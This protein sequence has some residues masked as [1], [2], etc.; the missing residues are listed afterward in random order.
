[1][2]ITQVR[3]QH[4]RAHKDYVLELSPETTV[5]TGANGSGK[6]SLTEAVYIALRGSSFK[7][8]D[9]DV[10]Q[11]DADW[12][13]ID[14]Q[15]QDGTTRTVKYTPTAETSKKQFDIDGKKHARL[16]AGKKHPVVLFEPEHLQLFSGSP[17]RRRRFIDQLIANVEPAYSTI[18]SRYDRALKQRNAAL[19]R[20]VS[21]DNLFAWNVALS[22][23]GEKIISKRAEYIAIMNERIAQSYGTIASTGD[24]ITVH[25][26]AYNTK[27]IQQQLLLQLE[28]NL[29]KDSIVG[30]TT[31][32][33]HRHDIT[34][35]F[36]GNDVR[37]I[38]S[39]GEV[40]SVVVALKY[41]EMKII[42]YLLG[43]RPLIILDDVHGELDA[44]RRKNL[45]KLFSDYQ[46][47]ITSTES[48]INKSNRNTIT[49][50]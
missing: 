28:A 4:V 36:N 27:G 15:L 33:P 39:R 11:V 22:E 26:P 2:I 16:P 45:T 23:Y 25:Y 47:I 38:A 50:L 12:Y 1:M 18:L 46:V 3:V 29:A 31:V 44:N 8:S 7:G 19:K 21:H 43:V 17:A 24:N 35:K 30:Y 41:I 49:K 37:R 34:F 40:K 14:V 10:L 20:G 48:N 32:G 9:A 5:I 13:R 6:T 42:E